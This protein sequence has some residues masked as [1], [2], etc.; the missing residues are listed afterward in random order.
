MSAIDKN[1]SARANSKKPR[2]TFT[3]FSHPPDFGIEL[4]Q[5][6]NAANKEKGRAKAREKP[7]IPTIGAKPPTVADWTN[8]GP[9]IGPV[10]E[11][12][13][14]ARVNAI[15]KMPIK[16]ARSAAL[17]DLLIQ[18]VGNE[19]SKAPKNEIAKI[20]I[21][22]KKKIF[23]QKPVDNSF[24]YEDPKAAVTMVPKRT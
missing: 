22:I 10:H 20:M 17:S 21:N 7:N 16:P 4:S 18:E 5:P 12:E 15:K 2:N 8:K 3:V 6:G 9:T 24:K 19:I 23:A 14:R 13:T 1:L 11:K